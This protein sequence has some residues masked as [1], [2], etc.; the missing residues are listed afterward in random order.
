MIIN[1]NFIR[2]R[3]IKFRELFEKV[4]PE[5]KKQREEKQR[6]TTRIGTKKRIGSYARTEAE[7]DHIVDSLQEQEVLFCFFK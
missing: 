6:L 1:L 7:L 4:F 2:S 5:I 3:E